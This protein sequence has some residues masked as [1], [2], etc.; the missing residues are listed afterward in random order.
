MYPIVPGKKIKNG[1]GHHFVNNP[2]SS[3]FQALALQPGHLAQDS[4]PLEA[5][6]CLFS[7]DTYLMEREFPPHSMRRCCRVPGISKVLENT[8]ASSFLFSFFFS[9]M[10][11]LRL[12]DFFFHLQQAPP[13]STVVSLSQL[14]LWTVP[15][16]IPTL[17]LATSLMRHI[18][19]KL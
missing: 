19:L 7:V 13:T 9:M 17:D 18:K 1:K 12:G 8:I 15:F 4:V 10:K 5:A 16:G 6:N 14:F 3:S 2:C 11:F